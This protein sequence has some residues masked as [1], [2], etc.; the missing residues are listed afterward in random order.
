[1]AYERRIEV[2][3]TLDDAYKFYKQN[4]PEPHLTKQEY[5][6]IAYL[7]NKT[8]ANLIITESFEYRIPHGLGFLRIK[9]KKLKF[10]FTD[11]KINANKYII[12]WKASW[13]YWVKK[14]PGLSRKEIK[15]IPNKGVYFQTNEH[16][17]GEI[18]R[19]YWD[20]RISRVKNILSYSFRTV[21]G[22]VIDNYY[23]GRLGLSE[24]INSNDKKNDYYY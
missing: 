5:K 9:K 21:K 11:G 20:K 12:D 1:M 18:M 8:I 17:N 16:T 19:W 23:M 15:E 6:K 7:L 3:H 2:T 24:W 10:K 4:Y 13:D 22:G 14:Y